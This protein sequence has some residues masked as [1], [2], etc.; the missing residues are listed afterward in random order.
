MYI[1][2]KTVHPLGPTVESKPDDMKTK[3]TE[4]WVVKSRSSW[5]S[6]KVARSK[7]MHIIKKGVHNW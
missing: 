2:I 5:H 3:Y 6:T 7:T 1:Y 4:R